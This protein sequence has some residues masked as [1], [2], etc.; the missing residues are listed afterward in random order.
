MAQLPPVKLPLNE[1][2]DLYAATGIVVGTK[3]VIHNNSNNMVILSD[4]LA[5]PV[6]G[7]GFDNIT[8]NEYLVSV[9]TPDGVWAFSSRG[10]ILQVSEA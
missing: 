10:A 3:V 8:P 7:S 9:D 5:E 2:V 6:G 1:W 4:S